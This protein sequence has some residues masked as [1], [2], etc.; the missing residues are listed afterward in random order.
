MNLEINYQKKARTY[1]N[2]NEDNFDKGERA[3]ERK[4]EK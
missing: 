4:Q 2:R 3:L 1:R